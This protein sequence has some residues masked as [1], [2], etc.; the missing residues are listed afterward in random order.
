MGYSREVIG[1][2]LGGGKGTNMEPLTPHLEKSL[3]RLLGKPLIYYPIKNLAQLG[4]RRMYVISRNPQRISNELG[5]YF[6]GVSLESIGQ[7]GDDL[8]SALK[9]VK[10][11]SGKGT[12]LISFG[13]VVLPQEA[14]ELALNSHVNSGKAIT[15]LMTPLSDLQGYFEV[16]VVDGVVINKVSTHKSGYAWTGILVTERD[17]LNSLYELDGDINGALRLFRGNVNVALWSGWFVDVSYPW[18]LL[19][20]IKYLL[21]DLSEAR[22]SKDADISPKAMVE[23]PVVID[24]GAKVDHGAII[25]GPVYIGND[26][27]VGNNA[28]IRNNTSLEEGAVIGADAEITESLIGRKATVGR[29]SFIGSSIIGDESTIEPGVVT[30]NVLPTGVEVSHLSPVIIKG[31][32]LAKLGAIVGPGTRIGAN[33]VI[34]PGSIVEANKYIQPLSILK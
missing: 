20:A 32:Q 23:G 14:Y 3:I 9:M 10:E 5:R 34:Y 2:V 11:V 6:E 16:E 7:G 4:L 26:V 21:S 28:I 19:S 22:V 8:N 15:V 12:T 33:S 18:D 17:F 30:L 29:G 13:D 31:K 1:V 27:Y 25:R 24:A